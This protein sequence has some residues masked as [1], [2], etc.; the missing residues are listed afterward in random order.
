MKTCKGLLQVLV[1][2]IFAL[3][4]GNVSAQVIF[5]DNFDGQADWNAS[6]QYEGAECSPGYCSAT[7]YPSGWNFYRSVPGS[8]GM[9]PV[10]SIRR[11][12][13]NLPD[14]SSGSGKA[15]VIYNESVSG[16]NWPGDGIIGKYLGAAANY[17]ELYIRFWIRTQSAWQSMNSAQSKILRVSNW[18][19]TDNIFQWANENTPIYFWDWGTTSTGSAAF[20][21]AYRCDALPY[22]TS[23]GR[24]ADYYCDLQANSYQKNDILYTW[25]TAA[26]VSKFADTSW[27][28]YDFYIKMNDIGAANGVLQWWYDGVQ[29][30][31]R[32]NV[33]WKEPT[34]SAATGWNTFALGGNSNNTWTTK[35]EQWYAIDDVVVSTTPIP[36]SYDIG[37]VTAPAPAAPKNVGGTS[38]K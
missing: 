24:S 35:G 21:P 27:H 10:V 12:P 29:V 14:H 20:L 3:F 34:A 2:L 23:T 37:G 31:S 16:V 19:A 18:R 1:G 26:A 5:E 17:K 6:N 15:I 4:S 38:V 28:R 33:I 25:G 8:T 9:S 7:T 22:N 32:T 30:E 11:L 13:G 36:D